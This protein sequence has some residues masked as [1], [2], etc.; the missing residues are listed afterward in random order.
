MFFDVEFLINHALPPP[1]TC[2]SIS[3]SKPAIAQYIGYLLKFRKLKVQGQFTWVDQPI[4]EGEQDYQEELKVIEEGI[5][6]IMII[7]I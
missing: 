2:F 5:F 3:G 7:F 1:P 6:M 4:K